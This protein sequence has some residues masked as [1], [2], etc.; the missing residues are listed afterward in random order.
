[1]DTYDTNE[2]ARIRAILL[3]HMMETGLRSRKLYDRI[4]AADG[5]LEPQASV[6]KLFSH[7][8]R[9]PGRRSAAVSFP[10]LAEPALVDPARA[11]AELSERR[12]HLIDSRT[13]DLAGEITSTGARL[14][15][16]NGVIARR[17]HREERGWLQADISRSVRAIADID[18][19]LPELESRLEGSPA[20]ATGSLWQGLVR[21]PSGGP[22][23][24]R[25]R[26]E[27][28]CARIGRRAQAGQAAPTA[29]G[30]AAP[31][32]SL[33][34]QWAWWSEAIEVERAR[35]GDVRHLDGP[36]RARP[37]VWRSDPADQPSRAV[38]RRPRC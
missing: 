36:R 24:A 6:L 21:A 26:L 1:M 9:S 13:R 33:S 10:N 30:H 7:F 27:E 31:P 17:R 15:V 5:M 35:L 12:Q 37:R 20:V 23:L 16:T 38:D 25:S 18:R 32:E 19:Q 3:K 14:E 8:W 29:T 28:G 11:I 34:A 4:C 22:D 2:R